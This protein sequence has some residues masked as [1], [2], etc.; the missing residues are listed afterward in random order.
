MCERWLRVISYSLK[1]FV[2]AQGSGKRKNNNIISEKDIIY[3]ETF[4]F[5]HIMETVTTNTE[6][7]GGGNLSTR[8][9]SLL[10][11][12]FEQAKANMELEDLR[13]LKKM[14]KI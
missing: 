10:E 3:D 12:A 6:Q 1:R 11:K 5:L 8:K 4:F 7:K 14:K 2:I 9:M 13:L